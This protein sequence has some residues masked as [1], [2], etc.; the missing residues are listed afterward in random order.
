MAAFDSK[1]APQQCAELASNYRAVLTTESSRI[2]TLANIVTN[3][4]WSDMESVKK[5]LSDLQSMKADPN[6]QGGIDQ[7]VD[8][9]D[10]Q[11]TSLCDFYGIKK[12]FDVKKE[13]ETGG[14]IISGL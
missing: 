13:S 9:A 6:L 10:K 4:N 8:G 5:A 14:S 12:P 11:V 7:A 2:S 1:P 3:V